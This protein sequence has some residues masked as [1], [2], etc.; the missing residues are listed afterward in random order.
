LTEAEEAAEDEDHR[1]SD[2]SDMCAQPR[3][4]ESVLLAETKEMESQAKIDAVSSTFSS[5]ECALSV[6][7]FNWAFYSR[8]AID[9][10]ITPSGWCI[11]IQFDDSP[12]I[13]MRVMDALDSTEKRL[14]V[15]LRTK[16]RSRHYDTGSAYS[17]LEKLSPAL[18]IDALSRLVEDL[19]SLSDEHRI[20]MK[21][22]HDRCQLALRNIMDEE[23]QEHFAVTEL[24]FL[25]LGS[26]M[27]ALAV[28]QGDSQAVA[29]V[30]FGGKGKGG[31]KHLMGLRL[32]QDLFA[33]LPL[34]ATR[35]APLSAFLHLLWLA[36]LASLHCSTL[37]DIESA[38]GRA[39]FDGV[40]SVAGDGCSGSDSNVDG[41]GS[42]GEAGSDGGGN[43]RP[44]N[45]EG[46]G[47]ADEDNAGENVGAVTG[48][49][50]N[51][52]DDD[53][54]DDDDGEIENDND[55]DNDDDDDEEE[56]EDVVN[57]DEVNESGPLLRNTLPAAP[58]P[59]PVSQTLPLGSRRSSARRS[60]VA[61]DSAVASPLLLQG[62]ATHKARESALAVAQ[63]AHVPSGFSYDIGNDEDDNVSGDDGDF[64]LELLSS[65][66]ILEVFRNVQEL[67]DDIVSELQ[68]EG[69]DKLTDL[70]DDIF[71]HADKAPLFDELGAFLAKREPMTVNA[72]KYLYRLDYLEGAGGQ[73]NPLG[74]AY[75][76]TFAES[77]RATFGDKEPTELF[78]E[79]DS[80]TSSNAS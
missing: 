58:A 28:A 2:G 68:L 64:S 46:E 49:N 9:V 80:L 8:L 4:E 74:H 50:R 40:S 30:S 47:E 23:D 21:F 48:E 39:D 20:L 31:G 7:P 59:A 51:D 10:G 75:N 22:L 13:F 3:I 26:L 25:E 72:L 73:A 42:N 14:L 77:C 15:A 36:S 29:G 12:H 57:D 5:P 41:D 43:A 6:A 32:R 33:K 76:P 19:K 69:T 24:V 37:N 27:D 54:D 11:P 61:A 67:R 71:N 65:D 52:I 56:E 17:D 63:A 53:D 66:Q 16:R 38:A 60:S 79:L 70:L 78:D 55:D 34:R 18:L 45:G 1:D 62:S 35:L 44:A